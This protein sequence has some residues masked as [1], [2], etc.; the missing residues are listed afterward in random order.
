MSVGHNLTIAGVNTREVLVVTQA[1]LESTVLSIVW[2]IVSTTDTIV[3]VLAVVSGV[4]TSWITDFEAEGVSTH[5]VVPLNSLGV[6]VVVA[7]RC[8]ESVRVNETTQWV[9]T[10]IST[11][12]VKFSSVVI[13]GQVK[14]GLVEEGDDLEVRRGLEELDTGDSTGGD[15]ASAVAGLGAPCDFLT[16]GVTDGSGAGG[17]SPNT[18]I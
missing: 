8:V 16:F 2:C 4:C 7:V 10:E 3:D 1:S 12:G 9:T 18:P 6:G 14:H 17:R 11:V 15:Q 13:R 5:E